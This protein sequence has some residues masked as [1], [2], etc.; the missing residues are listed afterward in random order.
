MNLWTAVTSAKNMLKAGRVEECEN[1][2]SWADMILREYREGKSKNPAAICC[3]NAEIIDGKKI[4]WCV[5]RYFD[6]AGSH[7]NA[8]KLR[9]GTPEERP[10]LCLECRM[11][12]EKDLN[13]LKSELNTIEKMRKRLFLLTTFFCDYINRNGPLGK[14]SRILQARAISSRT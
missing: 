8:G 13:R 12:C 7:I 5:K 3:F 11:K 2:I 14:K 4:I 1:L 10:D 6:G 9:P